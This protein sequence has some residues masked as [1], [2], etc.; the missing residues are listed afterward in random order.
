VK[1]DR[2]GAPFPVTPPFGSLA[3]LGFGAGAGASTVAGVAGFA[4]GAGVS[5]RR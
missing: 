4:V 3:G 1:L 5:A 2:G